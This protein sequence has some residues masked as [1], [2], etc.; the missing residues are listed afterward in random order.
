MGGE[1]G[2]QGKSKVMFDALTW[3]YL[4]YITVE[5]ER[6]WVDIQIWEVVIPFFSIEKSENWFLNVFMTTIDFEKFLNRIGKRK[7]VFS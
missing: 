1:R 4:V 6:L 5:I 7:V 3:K 2:Q